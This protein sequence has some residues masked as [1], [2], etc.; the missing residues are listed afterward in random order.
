MGC[1]MKKKQ[2]LNIILVVSILAVWIHS[3][4][5]AAASSQESSWVM[6]LLRPFLE[7]FV[8]RGNVTEHLVRKL[9]HFAEYFVLGAELSLWMKW[10]VKDRKVLGRFA[11]VVLAGLI[12][13]FIDESIQLFSIGRSAEVADIW[14]DLT[15]VIAA[16]VVWM[17]GEKAFAPAVKSQKD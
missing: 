15:G 8:G 10:N 16:G 6:N 4:M 5:P 11:I 1:E 3:A 12:V 7:L 2:I 9:A 13:A 17:I 14:L